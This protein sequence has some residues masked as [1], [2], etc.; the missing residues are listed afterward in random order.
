MKSEVRIRKLFVKK[1][2]SEP[3]DSITVNSL[4]KELE[5]ER[6]TFYYHYRDIYE[7]LESYLAEIKEEYLVLSDEI[8]LERILIHFDKNIEVYAKIANSNLRDALFNF[9]F[10]IMMKEVNYRI[11]LID[12]S[13]ELSQT[14]IM[15]ISRY[16]SLYASEFV[17]DKLKDEFN[18]DENRVKNKLDVIISKEVLNAYIDGYLKNRSSI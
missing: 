5:I 18:Y 16:V 2:A 10:D 9:V 7:V 13:K 3:I 14:S 6:Q 11:S 8:L 17:L 12:N 1:L 15:E 4:C